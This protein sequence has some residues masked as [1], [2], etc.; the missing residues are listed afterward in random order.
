LKIF[1]SS[2]LCADLQYTREEE[3][4]EKNKHMRKA[5][6]DIISVDCRLYRK[7]ERK[8]ETTTTVKQVF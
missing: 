4:E 5:L 7:K 2:F 3:E 1:S 6:V 8:N